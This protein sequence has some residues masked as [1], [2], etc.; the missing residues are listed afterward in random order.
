MRERDVST[1]EVH[2]HPDGEHENIIQDSGAYSHNIGIA[3][4]KKKQP[5]QA[6][7]QP[8]ENMKDFSK[9]ME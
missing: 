9:L 4:E 6:K 3:I 7:L 5:F 8:D 2:A 1:G